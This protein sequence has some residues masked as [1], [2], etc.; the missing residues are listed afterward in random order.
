MAYKIINRV[1]MTVASA[2]GTGVITLGAAVPGFQTFAAAA[3][4]MT[5]SDTVHYV[6]EDGTNWELG[7]GTYNSTGP[8][9]TRTT[10]IESNNAG[11][12]IN[13]S[14]SAIVYVTIHASDI[15][16]IPVANITG[17]LPVANGGTGITS[18]GTGVAT[19]LGTAVNTAGGA[20]V[21]AAALTANALVLGGG[22]GTGPSTTTTGTGVVTALGNAANATGG[23][24]TTD[25]SATLSNK[26]LTSPAINTPTI[27]GYTEYSPASAN[28]GT[29]TTLSISGGTVLRYTLTGNCTFT[30]PTAVAG[31]SFI[32]ILNTGAGS[33]TGTF[34]G[35]KWPSATAP[36]ITTTASRWD[37][38]SFFSD[39]TYWYGSALQAFA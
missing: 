14:A 15:T 34:T 27:T 10:V 4:S 30:M 39:G 8:T 38:I 31:Q 32:L 26:T 17:T 20:L 9:L 35:V 1:K 29:T 21:P 37:I 5:T 16:S 3:G 24:T 25:G 28:T 33:F 23:L 2:P 18:F 11:A 13:A 19:A 12:A 7:L 6:I 22:S 36:T